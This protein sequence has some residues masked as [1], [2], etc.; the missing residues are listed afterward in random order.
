MV[1]SATTA[2]IRLI[3]KL[4]VWGDKMINIASALFLAA[5]GFREA[6]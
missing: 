2:W 4:G 5:S 3:I 6:L 1:Y